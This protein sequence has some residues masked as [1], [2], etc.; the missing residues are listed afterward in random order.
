M[1]VEAHSQQPRY[2]KGYP[3]LAAF[4]ASDP[5]HTSAIF[6]RFRRLGARDLLHLQSEIAELQAQQDALDEQE[7]QGAHATKQ[8]SRNWPDF[9]SAAQCD[10]RQRERKQL[11]DTIHNVL[12]EYSASS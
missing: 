9:C 8:Y 4:I 3:S 7:W 12:R 10:G 1:D 5:D 2:L 11:A 6:K